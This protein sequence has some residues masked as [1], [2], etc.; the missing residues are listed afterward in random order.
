MLP[1]LFP[2]L[3]HAQSATDHTKIAAAKLSAAPVQGTLKKTPTCLF[4]QVAASGRVTFCCGG[5]VQFG[6]KS[7]VA[8]SGA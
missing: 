8:E 3:K 1:L 5:R 7:V 2:A 6:F 4:P